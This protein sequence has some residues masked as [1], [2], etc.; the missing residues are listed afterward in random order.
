[1][2]GLPDQRLGEQVAAV[3]VRDSG[4]HPSEDELRAHVADRLGAYAAPR[5]L[6]F[7]DVL[8]L[9]GPGKVDRAALRAWLLPP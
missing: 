6:R 1:V 9:R 5:L 2:L 7:A 3:I 8:P 4:A